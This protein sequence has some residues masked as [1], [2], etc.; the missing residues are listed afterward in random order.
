MGKNRSRGRRKRPMTARGLLVGSELLADAI[1]KGR[2]P[3]SNSDDPELAE[4]LARRFC[5]QASVFADPRR[6]GNP[7]IEFE[8]HFPLEHMENTEFPYEKVASEIVD[9]AFNGMAVDREGA[10]IAFSNAAGEPF[11]PEI[12]HLRPLFAAADLGDPQCMRGAVRRVTDRR[13]HR[14]GRIRVRFSDLL[15]AMESPGVLFRPTF[16]KS[17]EPGHP[18]KAHWVQARPL[19]ND[20][21]EIVLVRLPDRD[22][23]E[24]KGDVFEV[25]DRKRHGV[26][27]AIAL[28][29]AQMVENLMM[30]IPGMLDDLDQLAA[31]YYRYPRRVTPDPFAKA[32]MMFEELLEEFDPA[33]G[34][35]LDEDRLNAMLVERGGK[36][37]EELQRVML[38]RDASLADSSQGDSESSEESSDE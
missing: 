10:K 32:K 16:E 22:K 18:A 31:E 25:P 20:A 3:V 17:G 36:L 27:G 2:M 24:K 12:F 38:G 4:A 37:L 29:D 26:A 13:N 23:L 11:Q 33:K 7:S 5:W 21:T 6:P 14:P 34:T 15:G 28:L 1:E 30:I 19:D 8:L 9:F 35:A